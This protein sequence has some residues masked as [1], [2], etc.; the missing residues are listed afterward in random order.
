MKPSKTDRKKAARAAAVVDIGSNLLRMRICQQKQGE[1]W[2]LEYLEYPIS[3]GH[4]VF[5]SGKISFESIRAISSALQS[6]FDLA[7]EYGAEICRVVTTTA[8]REAENRAFVVDQLRIQNGIQVEILE[9]NQEKAYI[10]GEMMDRLKDEPEQ[11]CSM[12]SFIGTGSIGLAVLYGK[13][14]VFSRN[15]AIGAL[16][17]RDVL[18]SLQSFTTEFHTALEEY[19]QAT[20]GKRLA[21]F[22][23]GVPEMGRLALAGNDIPLI[24]QL[25]GAREENGRYLIKIHSLKELYRKICNLTP[26]KISLHYHITELQ[27]E[28]LYTALSIYVYLADFSGVKEIIAPNADLIQPIMK[29]VLLPKSKA[30]RS[31]KQRAD[32]LG[33][34]RLLAATF[35][36]SQPHSEKVA[37]AAEKIFDKMK[38]FHGLG[39]SKR[40]LLELAAILH[41]CGYYI[42]PKL[43]SVGIFQLLK[44]MDL[45][46]VAEEELETLAAVF[47]SLEE[48][49]SPGAAGRPQKLVVSKLSAIFRL[50]DALDY[51]QKQKLKNLK[52]RLDKNRLVLSVESLEDA[53]LEQWAFRQAVPFF[54]DVFGVR[55][56]LIIRPAAA[57]NALEL[58]KV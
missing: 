44:N 21:V 22:P 24:A 4:E 23:A 18:G 31:E 2:E 52:V 46:G 16:K 51:S 33:C 25:C 3:I 56:E 1:I 53:A 55:P 36:C 50:A 37:A 48:E 10:Y 26:A 5:T 27:A 38:K 41:E 12:F 54:E 49:L 14:I 40:F 7:R 9:D 17:L 58:G 35:R 8:L 43:Y 28:L 20:I 29:E 47:L 32:A 30:Q 13:T 39:S 11:S 34:A 6:F 42:H 19:L 57:A 15:I 45:Y